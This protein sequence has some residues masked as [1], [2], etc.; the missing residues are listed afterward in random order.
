MFRMTWLQRY[1]LDTNEF[2][3]YPLIRNWFYRNAIVNEIFSRGF[4][5]IY[6]G[7]AEG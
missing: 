5:R 6:I 4:I 7:D 1:P 2:V 3:S